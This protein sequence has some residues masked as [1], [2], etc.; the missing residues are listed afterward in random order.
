MAQKNML[1]IGDMVVRSALP[2]ETNYREKSPV[3]AEVVEGNKTV[4]K[5]Q[6]ILS[7]HNNYYPPSPFYLHGDLFAIPANHTIFC[8]VHPDGNLKPIY[9][10]I[11][12][13]RVEIPSILPLPQEQRK[14]YIDRVIVTNPGDTAYQEGDILFHRLNAAYDI[15]YNINKVENRITKLHEEWVI[16]FDR[17]AH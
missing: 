13:K 6:I 2:Y 14:T 12:C 3:V 9:G 11:L 5:G 15:V 1:K 17:L 10:N 7:H 16:G 8:I 4:R